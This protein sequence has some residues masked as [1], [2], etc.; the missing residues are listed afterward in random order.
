MEAIAGKAAASARDA[1]ATPTVRHCKY[2]KDWESGYLS[3]CP[4][5]QSW[6]WTPDPG[7]LGS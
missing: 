6:I 4:C 7:K 3:A 5:A 2:V 1:I